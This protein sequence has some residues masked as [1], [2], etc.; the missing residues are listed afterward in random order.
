MDSLRTV[1]LKSGSNQWPSLFLHRDIH[2]CCFFS[3]LT[4]KNVPSETR[5]S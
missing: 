4:W 1:E 5:R 3:I 2:Y